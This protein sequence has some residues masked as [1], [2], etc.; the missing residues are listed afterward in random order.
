[1][2]LTFCALLLCL[3][4]GVATA[5]EDCSTV[6]QCAQKAVEAAYQAKLALQIAVPKGAVMAFNANTCPE[7]WVDFAGAT[8]RVIVGVDGNNEKFAYGKTGGR[9]DIPTDGEHNH[10]VQGRRNE[11]GGRFGNDNNDDDW[12]TVKAGAHSHGGDNM[13][14]FISL[15]YCERQ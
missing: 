15:K 8:G 12:S 2:K 13:P 11:V 5:Q 7:G 4:H 1:M 6:A 3:S 10:K 14:P 9:A